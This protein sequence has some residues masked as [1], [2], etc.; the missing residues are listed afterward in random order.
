MRRLAPC[1]G[2]LVLMAMPVS[3]AL[4]PAPKPPSALES[5]VTLAGAGIPHEPPPPAA[6]RL[7]SGDVADSDPRIQFECQAS[8]YGDGSSSFLLISQHQAC[9]ACAGS[10]QACRYVCHEV[11]LGQRLPKPVSHGFCH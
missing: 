10:G 1:A 5:L 7:S 2:W 6:K 3:A 8:P 4:T 11:V 9:R